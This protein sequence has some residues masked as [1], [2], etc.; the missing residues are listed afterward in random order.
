MQRLWTPWR[1]GYVA[2]TAES[3]QSSRQSHSAPKARRE[4]PSRKVD[5]PAKLD[6]PPPHPEQR[7]QQA[8]FLCAIAAAP[9]QDAEQ[10]VLQRGEHALVLLNLYPYNSGHLMV[11]PYA[12]GG[13]LTQLPSETGHEV[14]DLT[15]RAVAALRDEYQPD[16]FNVGLNLGRPAGA[17]LPDH[18]HVHVVPR[19]NGDTNFMPVLSETKVLPEAL[20]QTWARL[21][22]RFQQNATSIFPTPRP[23]SGP[24]NV[25]LSHRRGTGQRPG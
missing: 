15:Q 5:T 24:G 22:P 21:R 13:D 20:D 8:C 3:A 18:L 7:D 10:L 1:M 6:Q 19:W 16:A 17:G 23:G 12:H 25:S 11:A 2:G 14:F 9:E 4:R